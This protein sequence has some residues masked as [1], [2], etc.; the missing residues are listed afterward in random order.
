MKKESKVIG[1]TRNPSG[2]YDN[3]QNG[4]R[5]YCW[6]V[7][8]ANGD[9]GENH[10]LDANKCRFVIDE[11]ASYD[12]ETLMSTRNPGEVWKHR[13]KYE[14]DWKPGSGSN[15]PYTPRELPREQQISIACQVAYE[16]AIDFC[17]ISLEINVKDTMQTLSNWLT[18]KGLT[19]DIQKRA[20]DC[21]RIAVKMM[22]IPKYAKW[23]LTELMAAAD[24]IFKICDPANYKTA[25]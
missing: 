5:N 19:G 22:N 12:I 25:E 18:S 4:K 15:K 6:I 9:K 2:D 14:S 17:V 1:I 8:F 20:C 11:N 7:E 24:G 23:T 3:K 10:S 16:V 13:I 21:L